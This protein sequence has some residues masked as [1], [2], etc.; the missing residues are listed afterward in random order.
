MSVGWAQSGGSWSLAGKYEYFGLGL[1]SSSWGARAGCSGLEELELGLGGYR[2]GA[3]DELGL[4]ELGL[5]LGLGEAWAG[6]EAGAG[7]FGLG[8]AG[9]WGARVGHLIGA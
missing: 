8:G 4:G 9:V 5:G 7:E 2:V 1:G 6:A 3:W